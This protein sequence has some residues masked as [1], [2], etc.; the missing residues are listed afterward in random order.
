MQLSRA[1]NMRASSA[2]P[3]TAARRSTQGLA[4][5]PT[6]ACRAQYQPLPPVGNAVAG[7]RLQSA[8]GLNN[9]LPPSA[10]PNPLFNS[11]ETA[12]Q[13]TFNSQT[14]GHRND[15]REVEGS[16]V[17]FPP[18]NRPPEAVVHFLGAAFVGAAP[19]I[20]YR[21]FLEALSNRNILVVTTPFNTT[22]DHL[23]I[24]DETQFKFDRAVRAMGPEFTLLPT[25]GV[26]HSLGAVIHLLICSRYAVARAGNVYLSFNN[27]SATDTVPFLAPLIAPSA[28]LLGPAL[29]AVAGSPVRATV[30]SALDTLRSM[31]PSIVRQVVPL[32]EQFLPM[33]LDLA[34]GREEFSPGAEE[35]KSLVRSYYAVPRNLLLRFKDDS[36]DDTSSLAQLLQASP[37]LSEVLDLSVRTLPGGHMRPMQQNVVDL[38]PEVARM[39]GT[40]VATAGDI[41]GRMAGMA[42]Q[43]GVPQAVELLNQASK[44][45]TGLAPLM[46]GEVG[47]PVTDGMQSLADEVATFVGTSSVYRAGTRALPAAAVARQQMQAAQQ[48]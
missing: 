7:A 15:W 4:R 12:I 22:F 6:V 28:K 8:D 35:T 46:G 31:S 10:S 14:P 25:Y 11:I 41:I 44:G 13:R 2:C 36:I 20:S 42:N 23:R 37:I 3:G 9:P 29:N 32:A 40:G 21:L 43:M 33:Y 39:A 16:Y 17:L 47:G 1:A 18:N 34:Q 26:G 19:Q 30:E 27:R 38:P 24:A 5:S 45:V 48:F